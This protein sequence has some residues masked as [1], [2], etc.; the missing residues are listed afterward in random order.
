MK[1]ITLL[2]IML[3]SMTVGSAKQT[4]VFKGEHSTGSWANNLFIDKESFASVSAGDVLYVMWNRDAAGV[5]DGDYYQLTVNYGDWNGK[6]VDSYDAKRV[7]CYAH[8]LTADEVAKFQSTGMAISGRYVNISQ[9]GLSN[10]STKSE[11]EYWNGAWTT[12]PDANIVLPEGWGSASLN[13]NSLKD[14][15]VGDVINVT[16]SPVANLS[17]DWKAELQICLAPSEGA[18]IPLIADYVAY[19]S[20]L[21]LVVNE[22]NL[23]DITTG[24]IR[25]NGKNVTITSVSLE[26]ADCCYRL[27][28]FNSNVDLSSLPTSSAVDVEL[29]R[30]YDWNTTLCVPFDIPNVSTAF[31]STAK[32]YEFKEYNSDSGLV[33]VERESIEA[34]KPY[35]MTFDMSDVDDSGK[36]Q[37]KTFD[38]VVI[39]TTLNNSAESGDLTFKG[40][41]T[42][43][44][45]MEG[46]YGV[47]WK[48]ESD[49]WG[50][51]KGGT[52]STLNAFCAY[53]D[54]TL[55]SGDARVG[56][57]L[58]ESTTGIDSVKN[59][60]AS[61]VFYSLAG[62][63]VMQ[64]TKGLYIM[65][66][67][68][69]IIK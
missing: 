62:Q 48:D 60:A 3:L 30:K 50:F 12:A 2:L 45:N 67:K 7:N 65:N 18:W 28:A 5:S 14:C 54:G 41:Y 16:F 44:M 13:N 19:K 47:A 31:G 43:G 15:K 53:F 40:N 58:E 59:S 21:C 63:R 61:T 20:S 25:L 26:T 55:A 39:N 46:K 22:T 52:G 23:S 17:E 34:G 10:L 4:V 57:V 49:G 51:Y 42:C 24:D 6:I 37:T 11:I 32:A 69:V 8:T 29:Y 36:Y 1:K 33:F 9:I 38:D 35:F 56:I 68:K 66:G 27:S 64:P